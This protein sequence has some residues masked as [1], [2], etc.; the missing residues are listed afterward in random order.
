MARKRIQARCASTA[1]AALEGRE[2]AA[3]ARAWEPRQPR[4]SPGLM[5]KLT[6][7]TAAVRLQNLVNDRGSGL[8]LHQPLMFFAAASNVTGP[9]RKYDSFAMWQAMAAW[10]PKT[11]SSTTGWR[12]FTALKKFIMCGDRSS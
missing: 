6:L 2:V 12:D 3:D 4:I 7:L 8:T 10:L 9:L 11:A 5:V 1:D